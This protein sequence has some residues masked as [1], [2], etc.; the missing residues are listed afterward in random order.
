PLPNAFELFGADLLVTYV[1]PNVGMSPFKKSY[2]KGSQK[3]A[4]FPFS[5]GPTR[6]SLK[7]REET[8]PLACESAW[9]FKY[10]EPAAGD[11]NGPLRACMAGR[12]SIDGLQIESANIAWTWSS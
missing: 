6:K 2:F 8:T 3:H 10:G 7:N 11:V 12:P 1:T 9:M 5:P 4:S